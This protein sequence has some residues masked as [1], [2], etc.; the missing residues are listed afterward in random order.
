MSP[1]NVDS[2]IEEITSGGCRVRALLDSGKGEIM[3]KY[4]NLFPVFNPN[5]AKGIFYKRLKF[6]NSKLYIVD[7]FLY[8][9]F[10]NGD[11]SF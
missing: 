6:P 2:G 7:G 4:S 9:G 10:Q 3:L 5:V 1:K 11:N 8:F